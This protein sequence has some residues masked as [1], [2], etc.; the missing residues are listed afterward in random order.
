MPIRS[1][2]KINK[3]KFEKEL[4]GKCYN[5]VFRFSNLLLINSKEVFLSHINNF[6]YDGCS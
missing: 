4:N 6:E 5:R 3:M 2:S 1:I